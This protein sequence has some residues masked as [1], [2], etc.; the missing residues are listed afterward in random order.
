MIEICGSWP[1][2]SLEVAAH[3]QVERLVGAAHLD[4]RLERDRV[5]GLEQR[6]QELVEMDRALRL[7]ARREV[8]AREEARHRDLRGH[9]D[10][11]LG[12]RAGASHA[13][14]KTTRV[15][16]GSRILNDLVAIRLGVGLAP[17][18]G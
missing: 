12:A 5:L 1:T 4:V 18:P 6:V 2:R 17:P 16:S 14:L 10:H 15:R 7:V 9:A 3:Q 11:V 8:L 13:E